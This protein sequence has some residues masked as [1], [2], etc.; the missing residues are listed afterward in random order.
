[1]CVCSVIY[2]LAGLIS[3][4]NIICSP[5]LHYILTTLSSLMSSENIVGLL[6]ESSVCNGYCL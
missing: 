3:E 1:M 4:Y 5:L 2:H 6:A